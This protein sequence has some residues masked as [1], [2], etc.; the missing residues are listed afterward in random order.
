VQTPGREY[1]VLRDNGAQV[2][3]GLGEQDG[4]APVWM[5]LLGCTAL[6]ERDISI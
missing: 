5:E 3:C 4:V 6:G 1:Y 2:G